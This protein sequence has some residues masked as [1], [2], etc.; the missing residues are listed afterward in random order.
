M[1]GKSTGGCVAQLAQHLHQRVA[2]GGALALPPGVRQ[3]VHR[4][5]VLRAAQHDQVAV[6]EPVAAAHRLVERADFQPQRSEVRRPRA[7][8][9]AGGC[10]NCFEP[11]PRVV[12]WAIS[13]NPKYSRISALAG[14][15]R[16]IVQ[17]GYR[18]VES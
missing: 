1:R 5:F 4:G 9:T 11:G 16:S 7:A 13:E 18:T 8:R 2:L 17:A 14:T 12:G 15:V 3:L 10:H 6:A